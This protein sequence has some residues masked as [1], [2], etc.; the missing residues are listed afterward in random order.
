MF[1]AG[2]IVIVV[3]HA[4]TMLKLCLFIFDKCSPCL[5]GFLNDLDHI[6]RSFLTFSIS[7]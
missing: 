7:V 6:A 5:H 1:A 4:E 3:Q 2:T